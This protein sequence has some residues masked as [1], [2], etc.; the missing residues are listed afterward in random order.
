MHTVDFQSLY[1]VH[2]SLMKKVDEYTE[3]EERL[4][5]VLVHCSKDKI[6]TTYKTPC[7]C[8]YMTILAY[9]FHN[10][11]HILKMSSKKG[12]KEEKRKEHKSEMSP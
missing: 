4:G 12:K 11:Y 3:N 5:S 9:F 7:G 8:S 2:K 10:T 1:S 6:N